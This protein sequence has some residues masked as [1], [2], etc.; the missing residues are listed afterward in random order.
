MLSLHEGTE[1]AR[2]DVGSYGSCRRVSGVMVA[3]VVC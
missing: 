2:C 1:Q 3:V